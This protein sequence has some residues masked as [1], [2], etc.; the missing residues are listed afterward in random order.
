MRRT[1]WQAA[2]A[3]LPLSVQTTTKSAAVQ[4]LL[5]LLATTYLDLEQEPSGDPEIWALLQQLVQRRALPAP[6]PSKAEPLTPSESTVQRAP[7]F[8]EWKDL[9]QPEGT[10][11][12][13]RAW[14]D[15][16]SARFSGESACRYRRPAYIQAW[17]R[18]YSTLSGYLETGGLFTCSEWHQIRD[19]AAEPPA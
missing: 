19:L 12:V 9:T 18:G 13:V 1:K 6:R 7:T 17:R 4:R 16:A 5:K 11:G 15:G 10:L 3:D 14:R 8:D 2:V